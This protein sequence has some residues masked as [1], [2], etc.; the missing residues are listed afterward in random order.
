M[1]WNGFQSG[2]FED[3]KGKITSNCGSNP[4]VYRKKLGYSKLHT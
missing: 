4:C 1:G 3:W 2:D